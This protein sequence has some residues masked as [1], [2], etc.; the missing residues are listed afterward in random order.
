VRTMQSDIE[1]AITGLGE[2]QRETLVRRIPRAYTVE[3]RS[4][5]GYG[6][7]VRS[8]SSEGSEDISTRLESFL[9]SL[10]PIVETIKDRDCILRVAIF[11]S[12]ATTT[13]TFSFSCLEVLRR[14]NAKLEVSV[15][16]LDD[17]SV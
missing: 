14:F 13:T 17:E 1:L 6:L 11:S 2:D 7:V 4:A 5:T 8:E 16:P 15:Y 12:L 9:R 3:D 10:L